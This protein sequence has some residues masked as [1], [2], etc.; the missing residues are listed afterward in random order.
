MVLVWIVTEVSPRWKNSDRLVMVRTT[1]QE[2]S[3]NAAPSA[4]SAAISTDRMILMICFRVIVFVF[5]PPNINTLFKIVPLC[6]KLTRKKNEGGPNRSPFI[7]YI[8]VTSS[9]ISSRVDW[10]TRRYA[11]TVFRVVCVV[12][13]A[14]RNVP[15][16]PAYMVLSTIASAF[17]GSLPPPVPTLP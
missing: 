5:F 17:F 8:L 13:G 12:W 3:P 11:S 4:V 14:A 1:L 16:V 10:M 2:L 9:R 15:V 6:P 7:P